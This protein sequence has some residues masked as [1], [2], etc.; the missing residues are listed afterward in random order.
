MT[1]FLALAA[2]LL[3]RRVA[4]GTHELNLAGRNVAAFVF[5]I[6]QGVLRADIKCLATYAALLDSLLML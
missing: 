2:D 5:L 4:L 6:S 3:I 1:T